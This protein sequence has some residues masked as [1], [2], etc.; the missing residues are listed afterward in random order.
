MK[1]IAVPGNQTLHADKPHGGE[2]PGAVGCPLS[3]VCYGYWL[4]HRNT[5]PVSALV[6]IVAYLAR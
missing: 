1:R 3:A 4:F 5:A 2:L 6:A